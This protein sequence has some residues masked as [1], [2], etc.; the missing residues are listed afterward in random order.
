M[1]KP[2]EKTIDGTEYL[3]YEMN[4]FKSAALLARMLKLLGKPI[5]SI[6]QG[7]EKKEG[8]SIMDADFNMDL[9]GMAIEELSMRLGEKE[10]DRLFKDLLVKELITYKTEEMDEFK[11]MSAVEQHFGKFPL[12]HLFKVLKFA[13]EVNFEDFF[14]GLA[15]LKE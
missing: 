4:P 5:S 15:E 12:L 1:R 9:I 6:I 11:K 13:L 2:H 14:G 7:I 8:E 3:M 10:V